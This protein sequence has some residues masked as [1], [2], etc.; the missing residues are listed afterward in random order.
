MPVTRRSFIKVLSGGIIAPALP[1]LGG[2][3]FDIPAP[4]VDAWRAAP[5]METEVRRWAL[6]HAL[7]APN[8]HNLQ[9]WVVDLG[10]PGRITLFYDRTRHLP[11][12]DPHHRQLIIG[13][14]AFLELLMQALAARGQAT[15]LT[16][17]PDGGFTDT[18]D[19]RPIA[20]VQFVDGASPVIDPLFAHIRQ[21]HTHRMPFDTTRPLSPASLEDLL[22]TSPHLPVAA[23]GTIDAAARQTL[24]GI[25]AQAWEIE[26][27]TPRTLLESV[28]LFR[29]GS[30]EILRHRD[31]IALTGFMP[32]LAKTLGWMSPEKMSDPA[33]T[34]Y[35]RSLE[36]GREQA[37]T[38]MG[39][40]WLTTQGNSRAQQ[41]DAGRAYARLHLQATALGVA[42]Q[43]MSQVLQEYAE[44][45]PVQRSLYHTLHIEPAT[46]TVQMLARLGYASGAY[47]SPRRELD[48]LIRT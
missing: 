43:P 29:I 38:A 31:G 21:R 12:T 47:P 1:L 42:L 28:R 34:G 2:C 45:D 3:S 14:G 33:S 32:N 8:P 19:A 7:L 9:P 23:Q 39:W 4:A 44:M 15:T 5:P 46:H 13:C 17:F 35:E 10:T 6:A 37:R 25:A 16:Y 22:R 18:P 11:E 36:M 27:R 30:D 41:L 48:T 40:A 20:A 24:S 26:V